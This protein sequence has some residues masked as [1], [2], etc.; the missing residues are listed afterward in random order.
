MNIFP[1]RFQDYFDY[2]SVQ[3]GWTHPNSCIRQRPLP[4]SPSV[5]RLMSIL[6]WNVTSQNSWPQGHTFFYEDPVLPAST[7]SI[8]FLSKCFEPLY[9][10]LDTIVHTVL[11]DSPIRPVSSFSSLALLSLP[12]W[13]KAIQSVASPTLR[14]YLLEQYQPLLEMMARDGFGD[15]IAHST[16]YTTF[17]SECKWMQYDTPPLHITDIERLLQY[18][19][20]D[21]RFERAH[22]FGWGVLYPDYR[23]TFQ[24]P[25]IGAKLTQWAGI[26]YL[27]DRNTFEQYTQ[28]WIEQPSMADHFIQHVMYHDLYGTDATN[29]E[30]IVIY[31]T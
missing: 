26:G 20:R 23:E 27:P 13:M 5:Q 17:H 9:Q 30:E 31:T 19:Y 16:T 10:A 2:V 22:Y 8:L 11:I 28:L 24:Y 7:E 21:P 3:L 18:H 12:E 4:S 1:Q 14:Y 15:F 25:A 6:G 29:L